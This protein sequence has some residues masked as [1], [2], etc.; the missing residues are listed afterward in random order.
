MQCFLQF[1]QL[2]PFGHSHALHRNPCPDRDD[3]SYIIFR[4]LRPEVRLFL[5]PGISQVIH[6]L[7][8]L[9][10]LIP[11]VRGQFIILM[12][13]RFQLFSLQL[14]KALLLGFQI[15]L[16]GCTADTYARRGLIHQVNCFIRQETI[17]DIAVGQ[18]D[19]CV[20]RFIC[21]HHMVVILITAAQPFED[22]KS[23]LGTGLIHFH[24]LETAG[25]S[26]IFFNMLAVIGQRSSADALQFAPRQCRLQ[27]AGSVN[28]ALRLPGADNVL[29][30]IDKKD[31]RRIITQLINNGLHALFKLAAVLGPRDQASDI[32]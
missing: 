26:G 7:A 20:Q 17:A 2:L 18:L 28:A 19:S 5:L 4:D 1:Q 22:L 14:G 10:L 15:E 31:D 9:P 11:E 8:Q 23:L 30:L 27:D 6:F 16:H 32:Q 13:N 25:K 12:F 29:K 24:G 21:Q 3:L